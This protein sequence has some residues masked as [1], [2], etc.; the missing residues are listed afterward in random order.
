MIVFNYTII[1]LAI[2]L[3]VPV[4]L[5]CMQVMLAVWSLRKPQPTKSLSD[6]QRPKIAVIVPAH[7]EELGL[8]HTL[9]HISPQLTFDDQ[10]VVVA[11]NCNDHTAEVARKSGAI[12]LERFN[13]HNRGKGFALDH[14]MQ[15]LH[16]NPPQVVVIIDADCE[17]SPQLIDTLARQCV[18]LQRPIQANYVMHFPGEKST[19]QQVVEFAW[20]VKNTIRPLGYQQLGLPCQLMG[21]G[22]AFLWND[23][24]QSNL[25]SGHLVEDMKLGLDL[26]RAGRCPSYTTLAEVKSYFPTSMEGI[27]TQRARW[28]HG[29]LGVIFTELP[30]YLWSAIRHQQWAMLAQVLDLMVPPLA[31]L[32]VSTVALWIIALINWWI[33]HTVL[34]LAIT[35]LVLGLLGSG[36]LLAWMCFG[37]D[38]I[39]LKSLVCAPFILLMKIPLYIKFVVSRQVD[40]VRSK[41]DQI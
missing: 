41:R 35:S 2:I 22:M 21:T 1:L 17:I 27:A 23:L 10:L 25:A 40:W 38:I 12:T 5:L 33:T 14:G 24:A 11:D 31:L 37:R 32:F 18:A 29:H 28:E 30:Q 8:A 19:K 13:Q 20:L 34:P 4:L 39:S 15:Y 7:N 9:A 3:L 36:I 16:K 6:T 26:A